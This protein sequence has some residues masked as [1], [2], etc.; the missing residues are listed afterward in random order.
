MHLVLAEHVKDMKGNLQLNKVNNECESRL[1]SGTGRLF[2]NL[3][4][5]RVSHIGFS[6]NKKCKCFHVSIPNCC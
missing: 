5:Y 4:Q 1:T 3:S 6:V 2:K